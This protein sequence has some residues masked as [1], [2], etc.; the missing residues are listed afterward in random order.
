MPWDQWCVTAVYIGRA[1]SDPD[2][3]ALSEFRGSDVGSGR[4]RPRVSALCA[5]PCACYRAEIKAPKLPAIKGKGRGEKE[6]TQ[7]TFKWMNKASLL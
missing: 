1:K 7:F 5:C 6:H 4:G 3:E 2:L